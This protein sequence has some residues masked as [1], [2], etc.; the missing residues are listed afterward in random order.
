[1]SR[2][3]HACLLL[4]SILILGGYSSARAQADFR[5]LDPGR[6]IAIED[7]QPIEFRAFE[8]Q[9]SLPRFVRERGGEWELGF[10]PEL[11]VGF[12]RDW[13]FGVSSGLV[14]AR[15]DDNTVSTFRDTQLHLLYNFNQESRQWPAFALRPELSLRSGALGSEHEHGSLKAIVS[16]TFHRNRVHWNASYTVGPTEARGRGGELVNRFFYGAAYERTFPL[17]FV[18]LLADVYARKPIDNGPTEV[19][20]EFGTRV[21]ASPRWVLDAGVASGVLRHSVGPDVGFTFGVSY[22]FSFR[23]L[24]PTGTPARKE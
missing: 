13:Q 22:S 24:F 8:L 14:V 11:K 15:E 7:A 6:P 4:G 18:V 2:P 1:M 10:E 3:R 16:K 5:N 20:F 17:R 23:S 12:G 19:V 21:Q 9:F